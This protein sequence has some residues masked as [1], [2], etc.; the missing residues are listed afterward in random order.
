MPNR[1]WDDSRTQTAIIFPNDELARITD[2]ARAHELSTGSFIRVVLAGAL[3]RGGGTL[4]QII[5]MGATVVPQNSL[6]RP[7]GSDLKPLWP[8][9]PGH[10]MRRRFINGGWY[11]EKDPRTKS[12]NTRSHA[13]KDEANWWHLVD[14][15]TGQRTPLAFELEEA[16]GLAQSRTY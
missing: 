16:L 6:R 1:R 5:Q 8:T 7:V 12:L 11:I 2:Q 15:T 3:L 9:V 14:E 13:S 4:D 10:V